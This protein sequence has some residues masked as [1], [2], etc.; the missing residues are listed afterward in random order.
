MKAVI[1][2]V[3]V[4]AVYWVGKTIYGEYKSKEQQEMKA[5]ALEESGLGSDGLAGMAASLEP[6]LKAAQRQG[7]AALK[8]WLDQYRPHL[9]DPKLA[10]IELDY[11]MQLARQDPRQAKAVYENVKR[12]TPRNSPIYPKVQRLGA[13]FGN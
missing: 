6:S 12:R 10:D 5:K 4:F 11:A 8:R 3:L 9:R 2:L 1:T 13:T 7:P